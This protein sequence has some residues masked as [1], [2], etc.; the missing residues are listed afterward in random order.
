MDHPGPRRTNLFLRR[1]PSLSGSNTLS[2]IIVLRSN[3]KSEKAYSVKNWTKSYRVE[4]VL[5]ELQDLKKRDLI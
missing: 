2:I 1:G 3:E 5:T 4:N